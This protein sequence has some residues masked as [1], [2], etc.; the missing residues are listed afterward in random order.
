MLA[1]RNERGYVTTIVLVLIATAFIAGPVLLHITQRRHNRLPFDVV[2]AYPVEKDVPPGE[3]FAATLTA[4]MERELS[5]TTG[6]RPNDFVLWG[7]GLWA[8]NNANRQLGII[9]SVRES[10]RVF[11]DHL[12]KISAS[13]YDQN[14]VEAETKFRNDEHKFWFPSAESQFEDGVRA[15]KRYVQGLHST[16]PKSK[17]LQRRNIE[18][19]R[20]FQSWSDLLGDAHANLFKS[21]EPDGSRV[22]TWRTD[23]YFYHAQGF[24]HVMH[25][26]TLA[27][28]RE[29]AADL[30]SRPT[31]ATLIDEVADALGK[32]AL[33]KPLIVLDGSNSGLFANHR[34][35][36]DGYV[37]EA[38]QKMYSIREELE[39]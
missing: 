31:V 19:I 16:P 38:R 24:A 4:L 21:H 9:Q 1:V 33:M 26:L 10:T 30:V 8:D 18:L 3:P 2:A 5:S 12:T 6:W 34:R 25:H 36:L 39:K 14:L 22:A 7:P 23:D 20:L 35:N 27:V 15:A 28:R 11:K 32:A 29:Y 17:P 37:V 13:E